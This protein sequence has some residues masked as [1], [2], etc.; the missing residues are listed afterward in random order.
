MCACI[1]VNHASRY[2]CG[3]RWKM[4]KNKTSQLKIPENYEEN[5]KFREN[6]TQLHTQY[7]YEIRFDDTEWII[8]NHIQSGNKTKTQQQNRNQQCQTGRHSFERIIWHFPACNF[9]LFTHIRFKPYTNSN[10]PTTADII[11]R[12]KTTTK[13][14][15][16][17]TK[18]HTHEHISAHT[19]ISSRLHSCHTFAQCMCV[20]RPKRHFFLYLSLVSLFLIRAFWFLFFFSFLLSSF[21]PHDFSFVCSLFLF[22]DEF[23]FQPTFNQCTCHRWF[24]HT[25]FLLLFC[26]LVLVLIDLIYFDHS[27]QQFFFSSLLLCHVAYI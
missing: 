6:K 17:S 2:C 3:Q 11:E 8:Y 7:W 22:C 21:V 1:C 15:T 9:V 4:Y 25:F 5:G 26:C 27:M 10:Q 20:L 13:K 14:T 18:A 12:K 19:W 16:T 23:C 24:H